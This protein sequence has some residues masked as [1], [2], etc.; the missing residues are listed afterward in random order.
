MWYNL[1]VDILKENG[2]VLNP[3]DRCVANKI[4][5][6]KQCTIMFYV[7][8]N[9]VSHEDP[10]VVDEILKMLEGYFG[11]METTRGDKHNFLGMD[12]AFMKNKTV[13]I[14]MKHQLLEAFEM[15]GEDVNE[16]CVIPHE[17]TI[18]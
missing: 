17:E 13:R 6:G 12:I 5:N 14:E 8:D 9:K 4:I 10:K 15:A 11:K 16:K 1:Y 2:F 18:I 3:Y 7:D